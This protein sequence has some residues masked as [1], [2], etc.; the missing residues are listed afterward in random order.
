MSDTQ[1]LQSL[2]DRP[3]ELLAELE[4]RARNATAA[5]GAAPGDS[6]EWT[7]IAVRI[8]GEPWLFARDEVREVLNLPAPLTR[9]PGAPAWI[10]GIGN[11]RGQVLP[12]VDLRAFLGGGPTPQS[13]NIRVVAVNHRDIPA[14]LLVDEVLGFRRFPEAAFSGDPPATALRCAAFAAGAFRGAGEVWPVIS[15]RRLL[16]DPSFSGSAA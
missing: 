5:P 14:G 7:G 6:R 2:R 4:R 15:L 1:T 8:A 9:V 10:L 13:R 16:E 11:V 12:V 3:L